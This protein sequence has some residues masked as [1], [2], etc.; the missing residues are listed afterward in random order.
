MLYL[1]AAN[2]CGEPHS[3]QIRLVSAY[4]H[5]DSHG[6]TCFILCQRS[7]VP[8]SG[9][10]FCD[11][12]HVQTFGAALIH[13]LLVWHDC[14]LSWCQ[15]WLWRLLLLNSF[16]YLRE[17]TNISYKL[18]NS[19]NQTQMLQILNCLHESYPIYCLFHFFNDPD[20]SSDCTWSSNDD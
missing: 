3:I 5:S 14:L 20:N 7:P 8:H 10:T 4:K 13:G 15:R 1:D 2:C 11:L 18:R 19:L 9:W 12:F 17:K 16:K 6:K